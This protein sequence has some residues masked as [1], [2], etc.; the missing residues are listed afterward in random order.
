MKIG[1]QRIG[2]GVS[3]AVFNWSTWFR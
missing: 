1:E 3:G 2:S